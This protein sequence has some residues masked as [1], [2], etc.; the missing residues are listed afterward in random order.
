MPSPNNS[1]TL[2]VPSAAG[3]KGT[4]ATVERAVDVLMHI[5]D[6]PGPD[7]GITELAEELSMSKAA[8]HRVLASLKGR[9]LIQLDER[10]RRY[11]LGVAAL[12]LGLAY[13]DRIDVRRL[14]RPALEDLSERTGE[15]A[16]LSVLLGEHQR[17]YVDQ[18]TPDREVILSVTMGE[19]YPLHAGASGRVFLAFLPEETCE[20]YLGEG[21]LKRLTD[22][23][24]VDEA[25]LRKVLQQVRTD[26]W[27]MSIGE[28]KAGAAAVAAP[29]LSHDGFPVAVV[30]IC[31][32]QERFMEHLDECR[33]EL[34][35]ASNALSERFGWVAS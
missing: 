8:V 33:E 17:I 18:V 20:T 7:F 27:A 19:P 31:G 26:G 21:A 24:M 12:R 30:S 29:V 16:T 9:G 10:T 11:S 3:A 32:P 2:E 5:A 4:I 34:L 6:R 15:T 22:S 25:E 1:T 23:T 14:G 35:I 13:L 28:R